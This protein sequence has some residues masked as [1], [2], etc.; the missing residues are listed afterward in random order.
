MKKVLIHC[1]PEYLD[2]VKRLG[3]SYTKSQSHDEIDVTVNEID[4]VANHYYVDPDEQLCDHYGIE[5]D[6]VNCIELV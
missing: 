3:L 1:K 4:Y 6:Y 5:Y 2:E